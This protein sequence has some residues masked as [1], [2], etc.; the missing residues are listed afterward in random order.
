VELKIEITVG[1]TG[2]AQDWQILSGAG[3]GMDTAFLKVLPLWRYVPAQK[4]GQPV[5]ART[6]LD[7][8]FNFGSG[9]P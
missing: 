4:D 9:R 3:S 8:K 2:K 6:T 1:I 7:A 5:T